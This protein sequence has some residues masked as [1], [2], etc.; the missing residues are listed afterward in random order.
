MGKCCLE[1]R[2]KSLARY[3]S[4]LEA[5]PYSKNSIIPSQETFEEDSLARGCPSVFRKERLG[6]PQ[7]GETYLG[8]P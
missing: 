1:V 3:L 5:Q 8:K 7:I 6:L 2:V 4:D